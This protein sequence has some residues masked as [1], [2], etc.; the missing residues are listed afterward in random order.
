[1]SSFGSF[2][3]AAASTDLEDEDTLVD[4]QEPEAEET[5]PIPNFA[6]AGITNLTK[7]VKE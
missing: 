6:E 3:E 4:M 7:I 1:M 2:R 5:E